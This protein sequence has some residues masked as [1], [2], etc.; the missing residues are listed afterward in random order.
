MLERASVV[1]GG[2]P[3]GRRTVKAVPFV[4]L[5]GG[6]VQ[7]VVSSGSDVERVYVSFIA[8]GG[9]YYCCT[10]NNR[11][12]GGLGGGP[13]KHIRE[14]VDEAVVQCGAARVAE[15]L[16]IAE[17]QG[18]DDGRAI[19]GALRGDERKE[20]PGEVFSRF[21]GYL[22]YCELQARPGTVLEMGWFAS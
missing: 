2:M 10:N 1:G 9:D 19:L 6:R 20:S 7:G 8:S 17:A 13:C 15:Y 16:G 3:A 21:L 14:M 5:A 18:L 11:P 12:C 22:R 4:E